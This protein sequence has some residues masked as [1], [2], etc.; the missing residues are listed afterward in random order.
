[1]PSSSL[2]VSYTYGSS[3]AVVC[4]GVL[5]TPTILVL[6]SALGVSQAVGFLL[7][8]KEKKVMN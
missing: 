7:L 6:F 8:V 2:N 1:M 4:V 3:Q 5:G